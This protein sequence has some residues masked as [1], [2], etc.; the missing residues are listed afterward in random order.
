MSSPRTHWTT[1][2]LGVDYR[3]TARHA[4]TTGDACNQEDRY[5]PLHPPHQSISQ[6]VSHQVSFLLR[7]SVSQRMLSGAMR[8][9]PVRHTHMMQQNC[10]HTLMMLTNCNTNDAHELHTHM[11]KNHDTD[12]THNC[13]Q[14]PARPRRKKLRTP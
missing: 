8:Q 7:D 5:K 10:T 2:E 13:W 9:T 1:L 12:I 3:V 14:A 4:E 11:T 6:P